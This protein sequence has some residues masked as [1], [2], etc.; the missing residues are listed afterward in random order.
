MVGSGGTGKSSF[1]RAIEWFFRGGALDAEDVHEG[2]EGSDVGVA[3]TFSDIND[4]DRLVLG[5]Y[6]AGDPTT[7]T[8]TWR[9]GESDKLSGSALFYPGFDDVRSVSGVERRQRFRAVI[10]VE[11][12]TF[13]FEGPAPTRV[14]DVDS[15]MDRL[16]REHPELCELRPEDASHL[17][18][19]AGGPRL[20]DRFDYVLVGAA[21]DASEALS[22]GRNSALTRLLSALGDLDPETQER[23]GL[24]QAEAQSQIETL[25]GAARASGL[26]EVA[27]GITRRVQEYVPRVVVDLADELA[28][29]RPPDLSVAV[30]VRDQ[31]G[32]ATDVHRHGH[33]LQ[34]ALVIA[35]LHELAES[36]ATL[37]ASNQDVTAP[38]SLMLAIEEPELYQHPL[39]ARSLATVLRAIATF[40]AGEAS[41]S[42]QIA[43]STHSSHFVRP[44]LYE[45]IRVFRRNS[46]GHTDSV[47]AD[48]EK[49]AGKLAAVEIDTDVGSM[50]DKTLSTSLAEAVFARAVLLCEGR[51]DVAIME[52]T[53]QLDGG[54]DRDGIA[55]VA[56]WGKTV[57]PVAAAILG[58][59]DI[60]TYVLFDADTGLKQRLEA[61]S[62]LTDTERKAQLRATARK[63][64]QLLQLCGEDPVDWPDRTV[65]SRCAN[66]ADRPEAELEELWP[67][68]SDSRERVARDLGMSP[69][70]DEAYRRAVEEAGDPPEFLR[71]IV[72]AVRALV[73]G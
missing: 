33:G 23:I 63:N 64:R 20:T 72:G 12:P 59:L 62:S 6:A 46:E 53:A 30:R 35:L 11:G 67:S 56:C 27:D 65:R 10:E 51:T 57:I 45:N 32:Y 5:R 39:Q 16:E 44:A 41:R 43:Y 28:P 1:L 40:S 31:S 9:P 68:L 49:V 70:T 7:F 3:V 50:V 19:F 52:A 66:F 29:A 25:V 61:K 17:F 37:T 34:R 54:F 42:V 14:A 71:E 8:R 48:P 58:Q 18:G 38:R 26:R 55:V 24:V 73:S 69:K 4:A 47:A 36:S 2:G 22:A 13:G 60:P 15:I 21:D